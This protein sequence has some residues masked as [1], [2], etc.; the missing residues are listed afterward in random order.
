MS[1][2]DP[3]EKKSGEIWKLL[4]GELSP[5]EAQ[6]TESSLFADP[7]AQAVLEDNRLVHQFLS[8]D[9]AAA[10]LSDELL[11][12]N[13]LAEMDREEAEEQVR[14]PAPSSSWHSWQPLLALAACFTLVFGIY[15][16]QA[17]SLRWS[18]SVVQDS[19]SRGDTDLPPLT[20]EEKAA[21]TA[22]ADFL[23]EL[24]QQRYDEQDTAPRSLLP[25]RQRWQV[26]TTVQR[27]PQ[28]ALLFRTTADPL[29]RHLSGNTWE[30][31]VQ[32]VED[33]NVVLTEFG[34]LVGEELAALEQQGP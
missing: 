3:I 6:S 9:L 33:L 10:E 32:P 34:S 27:M 5:E 18:S 25:G 28:G 31:A 16:Y 14:T 21:L 19:G 29:K 30:L 26:V 13:I 15:N 7:E 8:E 1:D 4:H 20:D 17:P 11:A 12:T 23:Q 2:P 22:H 24:I